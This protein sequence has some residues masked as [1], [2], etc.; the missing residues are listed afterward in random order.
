MMR[1]SI[2][3]MMWARILGVLCAFAACASHHDTGKNDAD[4]TL[5]IGP[6]TSTLTITNGAP[7]TEDFTATLTYPDGSTKDITD[8]VT[9]TIDSGFGHYTA[10]TLS[11][12]PAGKAT[13]LGAWSTKSANAQVLANV[14]DIRVDPSLPPHTPDLFANG[15][16]DPTPAPSVVY[17]P[18][19]VL[20][21]RTLGA[22]E[23]HRT[24]TTPHDI[25]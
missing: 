8:Q 17:P 16:E 22:F 21:P 10:L 19:P 9:F 3:L 5:S 12:Q 1:S 6:P 4:A 2:T 20:M 7:A 25:I 23:V 14:K 15:T 24:A 13:V 11:M 18:A